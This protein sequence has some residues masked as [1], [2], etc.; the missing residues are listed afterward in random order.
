MRPISFK[1]S[2]SI[3]PS[4]AIVSSVRPSARILSFWIVAQV[5]EGQHC[6]GP[7][8][9]GAR[10]RHHFDGRTE[11]VASSTDRLEK[12]G[13]AGRI[14]RNAWRTLRTAV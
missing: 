14:V 8:R 13:M 11:A 2:G 12:D 5:V 10:Q 3:C 1:C 7:A 6:Q 4:V 9:G